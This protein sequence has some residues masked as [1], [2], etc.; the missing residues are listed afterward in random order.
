MWIITKAA[1]N[2]WNGDMMVIT[3]LFLFM[4]PETVA[5]KNVF[6]EAEEEVN[7]LPRELEPARKTGA[8]PCEK[9]CVYESTLPHHGVPGT[10]FRTSETIIPFNQPHKQPRYLIYVH[11]KNK[12]CSSLG[13]FVWE[14]PGSK[15]TFSI[16]FYVQKFVKVPYCVNELQL[17]LIWKDLLDTTRLSKITKREVICK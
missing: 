13:P 3:Y 1:M 5:E 12:K 8:I 2:V 15:L 4:W 10:T 16:F 7:P 9:N 14:V 11:L 17:F 6:T